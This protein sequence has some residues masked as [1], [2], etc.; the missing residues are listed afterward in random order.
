MPGQGNIL[1]MLDEGYVFNGLV[2]ILFVYPLDVLYYFLQPC[3]HGSMEQHCVIFSNLIMNGLIWH[4][5]KETVADAR[6]KINPAL[7]RI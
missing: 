4:L 5:K 1:D 2:N 3:S 6:V 7:L